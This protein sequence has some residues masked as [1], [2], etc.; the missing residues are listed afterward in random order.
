MLVRTNIY[1]PAQLIQQLKH[2]AKA[3]GT[4]MSEVIRLA[5]KGQQ[6]QDATKS[7]AAAS[8]LKRALKAK[9]SGLRD[10]SIRHDYYL[11]NEPKDD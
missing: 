9:A 10:I 8:L 3:T 1:L 7:N 6:K 2:Q 11:A 5:L 4:S